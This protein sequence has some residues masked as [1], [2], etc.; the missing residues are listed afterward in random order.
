VHFKDE[1]ALA[2]G[3]DAIWQRVSNLKVIPTYWPAIRSVDSLRTDGTDSTASIEFVF[4]GKCQATIPVDQADRT[5]LSG[6]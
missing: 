6:V 4:G 5:L 3:G 2:D 1:L